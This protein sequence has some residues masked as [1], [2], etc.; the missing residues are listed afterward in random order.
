MGACVSLCV[1]LC[2]GW[3]HPIHMQLNRASTHDVENSRVHTASCF[4]T[5]FQ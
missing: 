4:L 2:V 5:L 1:G 3:E